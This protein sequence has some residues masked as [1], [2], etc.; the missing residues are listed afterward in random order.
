MPFTLRAVNQEKKFGDGS[1]MWMVQLSMIR[2]PRPWRGNWLARATL[3]ETQNDRDSESVTYLHRTVSPAFVVVRLPSS[4][5]P[6][7][8]I[9]ASAQRGAAI[10]HIRS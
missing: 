5:S 6:H 3:Q 1:S 10:S 8:N 7:S 9:R 4:Q 2:I